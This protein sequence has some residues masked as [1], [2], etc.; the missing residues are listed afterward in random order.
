MKNESAIVDPKLELRR[1]NAEALRLTEFD[2]TDLTDEYDPAPSCAE[3]NWSG[4]KDTKF[5]KFRLTKKQKKVIRLAWKEFD[6]SKLGKISEASMRKV[7]M[8]V[9]AFWYPC[10]IY[11]GFEGYSYTAE[12]LAKRIHI[13]LYPERKGKEKWR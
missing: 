5:G 12:N 1:H 2:E 3:Y 11:D 8:Y 6:E 4:E 9:D 13:F 10:D 7:G